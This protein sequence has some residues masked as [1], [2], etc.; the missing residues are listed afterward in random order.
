MRNR[1]A[2]AM[3]PA[4]CTSATASGKTTYHFFSRTGGGANHSWNQNGL[5]FVQIEKTMGAPHSSC[6]KNKGG[7]LTQK[8]AD[9]T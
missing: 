4:G 1:A 5:E 7:S 6:Q 9:K 3:A 2:H 8:E